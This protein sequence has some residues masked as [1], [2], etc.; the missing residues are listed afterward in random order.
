[1]DFVTSH[2]GKM[3]IWPVEHFYNMFVLTYGRDCWIQICC[4]SVQLFRGSSFRNDF[5][6]KSILRL[7]KI[8]LPRS[9]IFFLFFS[10]FTF[11]SRSRSDPC[12]KVR[13]ASTIE[14]TRSESCEPCVCAKIMHK[15]FTIGLRHRHM[16]SL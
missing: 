14:Q 15:V 4:K 2:F 16:C 8:A 13:H 6:T 3:N 5:V 9:L 1:M 10:S 12:P 11:F 7:V